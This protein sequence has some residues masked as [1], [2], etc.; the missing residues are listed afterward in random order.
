[1]KKLIGAALLSLPFLAAAD[2]LYLCEAYAGG[3]FWSSA[4]CSKNQA[5]IKRMFEVPG[6][7]PFDQ[8]VALGQQRL[9]GTSGTQAPAVVQRSVQTGGTRAECAGLKDRIVYLDALARQPQTGQT[10]DRIKEEKKQVRDQQFR[11]RC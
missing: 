8:Q 4:H 5:L 9:N 11:L 6:G 10:Q 7:L 2:T 1:M 3:Q